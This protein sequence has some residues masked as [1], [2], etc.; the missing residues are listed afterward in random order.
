MILGDVLLFVAF[1]YTRRLWF[2]WGI[3]WGWNFFQDGVFGMPN[4]GVTE[5]LSWIRPVIRGPEWITGGGFGIETSCIA[6]C[7]SFV[8]GLLILKTAVDK[9]QIVLP[10]WRRLK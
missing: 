5:F 3:H 8:V 4:S 9:R 1:I 6:V 10:V 7:L 2:V